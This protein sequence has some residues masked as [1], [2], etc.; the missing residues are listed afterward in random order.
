MPSI[1]ASAKME[2]LERLLEDL[3]AG[4]HRALVFS[5]FVDCLSI[6]RKLAEGHGWT[7]KYLDGSTPR[8]ARETAV[9][10][11]QSGEG[12]FF[13][14]SL[15][16]GGMGLNLTAANYVILLDPWWNPA[17]ES[18]AADR[19]HRIGQ[20]MPVT[21]YRLVC[22]DTIEEKVIELHAKKTAL[23]ED[24]LS[25]GASPLG[26]GELLDLLRGERFDMS[27][28]IASSN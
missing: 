26:A 21:V 4:G 27:P 6:V 20:T 2:A 17:V 23:A 19:T 8:A 14:I 18:Q 15:K 1:A 3:R 5:Q 9:Q 25:G 22:K 16:A 11:F 24:V 13:F 7:Y 10:E 12:D 28:S